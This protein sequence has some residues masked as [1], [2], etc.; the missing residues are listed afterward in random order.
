MAS[1]ASIQQYLNDVEETDFSIPNDKE[2]RWDALKQAIA[3]VC[4]NYKV[5]GGSDMLIGLI[6]DELYTSTVEMASKWRNGNVKLT[7]GKYKGLS[8]A[9]IYYCSPSYITYISKKSKTPALKEGIDNFI[10]DC[11]IFTG[12]DL[13][14]KA[15][16]QPEEPEVP[17]PP[18]MSPVVP[19]TPVKI[20]KKRNFGTLSMME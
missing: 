15:K 9:E 17:L 6:H 1:K 10:E 8:L 3:N 14:A 18:S 5:N 4:V 11:N 19:Q 13:T 2:I 20:S 12:V 7:F 16:A